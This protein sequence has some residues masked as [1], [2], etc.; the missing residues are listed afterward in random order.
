MQFLGIVILDPDIEMKEETIYVVINL[1]KPKPI[2]DIPV[3][4]GFANFHE[5]F[6]K[7]F[8]KTI[9]LLIS[10]LK[11]LITLMGVRLEAIKPMN[12]KEIRIYVLV[13]MLLVMLIVV[14]ILVKI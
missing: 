1:A 7:N 12:M 8:N 5:I 11:Q 10:M 13:F 4:S 9:A 3:F 14:I 2:K 6:I